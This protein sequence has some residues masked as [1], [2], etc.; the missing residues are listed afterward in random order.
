MVRVACG[1]AG[2][3]A[4]RFEALPEPG[5]S[6][7]HRVR[8]GNFVP[9]V[10]AKSAPPHQHEQRGSRA[11][12][13]HRRF[14]LFDHGHP[15]ARPFE[16][17]P[18]HGSA[19]LVWPPPAHR[20]DLAPNCSRSGCPRLDSTRRR[21]RTISRTRSTGKPGRWRQ[22]GTT[23]HFGACQRAPRTNHPPGPRN[24]ASGH[25]NHPSGP[26]NR[27]SGPSN[28]PSGPSNRPKRR[29]GTRGPPLRAPAQCTTTHADPL[30]PTPAR[31]YAPFSGD[32]LW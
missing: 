30:A 12:R 14:C 15:P 4:E 21:R 6:G 11:T 2:R 18:R 24:H 3:R 23:D 8:V 16:R 25:R 7:P 26:T 5:P 27:A 29:D 20:T 22:R 28:H 31:Q 17:P 1:P 13:R 19:Y 32:P 10:P 9:A